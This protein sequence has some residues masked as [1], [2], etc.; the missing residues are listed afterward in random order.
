M[1]PLCLIVVSL[2]VLAG[3]HSRDK[4][5]A[6]GPDS[7]SGFVSAPKTSTEVSRDQALQ[8]A[9]RAFRDEAPGDQWYCMEHLGAILVKRGDNLYWSVT[10]TS[11]PIAG[12]G[13]NALVDATSGV[14]TRVNVPKGLR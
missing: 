10:C 8:L 1:K 11:S 6:T 14:V 3:C 7:R 12:G 5:A 4:D 13:G 9:L 2:A